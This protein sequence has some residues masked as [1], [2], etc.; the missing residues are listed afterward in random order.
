MIFKKCVGH[1]GKKNSVVY[2]NNFFYFCVMKYFLIIT[3]FLISCKKIIV[4]DYQ[5]R[6]RVESG[7][8]RLI[9]DYMKADGKMYT[10]TINHASYYLY[11]TR[12]EYIWYSSKPSD[13]YYVKVRND[14]TGYFKL[15]VLR[16]RDTLNIDASTTSL[17]FSKRN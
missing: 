8:P 5:Y 1:F 11:D 13:K 16:N 15:S 4:G 14:S 17:T 12:W 2:I 10:D 7:S 3:L 9:V 6:Y